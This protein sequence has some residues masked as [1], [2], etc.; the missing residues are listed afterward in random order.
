MNDDPPSEQ[1]P[2]SGSAASDDQRAPRRTPPVVGIGASAGGIQSFKEFLEEYPTDGDMAI[3]FL[4]HVSREHRSEL[5]DIL[6]RK[7][8]SS[9]TVKEVEDGE[10]VAPNVIYTNP[11]SAHVELR[12]GR[13]CL[14]ERPRAQEHLRTIDVFFQSL[15]REMGD[16][17]IAVIL[18]GG[19]SDGTAGAVEVRA[20]GGTVLVQDPDTAE[21]PSM[22]QS[23]LRRLKLHSLAPPGELGR[24][25]ARLVRLPQFRADDSAE[26]GLAELD[27]TEESMRTIFSLIRRAH[28]IDF[29]H[30][31]RGTICRRLQRRMSLAN[32]DS[33]EEYLDL[34]N[35]D[36]SEVDRLL[37]DTLIHVTRF[38]REP[39]T[40][41]AL[42][43][44]VFGAITA[45]RSEDAPVRI[46]VP[47]CSTGEEAFSIAIA[48]SEYAKDQ[49]PDR[50]FQIFGSDVSEEAVLKARSGY[51]RDGIADDLSPSL[52]RTYFT[53]TE[54]GFQISQSIR[55]HCIFA[56]QDLTRD[57]PFSRID[58]IVCRNVLI[59]LSQPM[60]QK[61]MG[62]F[63][64][65]L[66]PDGYLMLGSAETV[67]QQSDLFELVDK[68]SRIYRKKPDVR[69]PDMEFP[70]SRR[71][72]S[73]ARV[74]E[75]TSGNEQRRSEE[76]S[77]GDEASRILLN[78][79]CPSGV[80]VDEK[81]NVLQF[82][83]QTGRFLQPAPGEPTSNVLKMAREGLLY[84]LNAAVQEA[85]D[86]GREVR[87][88]NLWV[89]ANGGRIKAA[90]Q[91]IP[92]GDPD[93][94]KR[95]FLIIFFEEGQEEWDE[96]KDEEESEST[97]APAGGSDHVLRQRLEELE[98][99]R[100]AS[101]E[102]MQSVIQDLEAANEELQSANEEILSSNEELQSTN[103]ELDT[104]KEEL[105]S[106]NEE[107]NTVNDELQNRNEKL[108]RVHSDLL[109][110]LANIDVSIV[111]VSPDL[112]V[113]R[114]TPPAGKLLNLIEGD[115]GR[116]IR[117]IK[118]NVE[119]DH[120]EGLIE[121]VIDSLQPL[122]REVE[123]DEGR[124]YS[125]RIRPYK[126]IDRRID[127][128]VVAL[129]DIT[130]LRAKQAEVRRARDFADA[131]LNAVRHPLAVLDGEDGTI[132]TLRSAWA[133]A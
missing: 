110:L 83:G 28:G 90:V 94:E 129:F 12:D 111:M 99:E 71:Y 58:L 108:G 14:S 88:E 19:S 100:A 123:S 26:A 78:H 112:K 10:A 23:V 59:Y 107:L 97:S 89:G 113:R 87:R 105:Q 92:L 96:R 40:F 42:S 103:E 1:T 64:Y 32:C 24:E 39:Q 121:Q 73:L 95:N 33:V 72:T 85:R 7:E 18:S 61:V 46:W 126:D 11:P 41:E 124:V 75:R 120:F 116:P 47:G 114:F 30:Y 31:K 56:R 84:A 43:G 93:R 20:V 13:L 132:K 119:I 45:D 48:L 9:L 133:A 125:L 122:E 131:I 109:N 117:Q 15:S 29:S 98:R 21:H 17:A 81:L 130:D 35:N 118:P 38:F 36:E 128:A 34:L 127:G 65:A 54:G 91:V 53:R 74:S 3:V 25:V 102:Y 37:E 101:R 55:D 77:V 67:G 79:F 2:Q 49:I 86:S 44:Q 68:P 104:A 69:R 60:Q 6:Q 80:V 50:N 22:P 5:P 62:V 27:A 51:Y 115:I 66:R 82:R 76:A 57:P 106:T 8:H 70:D 16:R 4:L 63:H 52:L